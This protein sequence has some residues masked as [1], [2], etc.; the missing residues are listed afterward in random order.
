M[1]NDNGLDEEDVEIAQVLSMRLSE[2]TKQAYRSALKQFWE[3]LR[4]KHPAIALTDQRIDL[5]HLTLKIIQSFL[6]K[7]QNDDRS[8]RS[9]SVHFCD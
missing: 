1:E 7:R 6:V 9:L 8:F 3:Y 2:K 4:E 5:N